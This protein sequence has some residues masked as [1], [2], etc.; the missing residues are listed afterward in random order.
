MEENMIRLETENFVNNLKPD[1][2]AEIQIKRHLAKS[3][4]EED[5]RE[6]VKVATEL[7][8]LRDLRENNM[9]ICLGTRNNHERDTFAAKLAE[10]KVHSLDI[11]PES[12]AD[13]IM[14]FT[15]FPK[16]WTCKWDLI[17]SNSIDHSYDPTSTFEE[18]IRVLKPSGILML[19]MNYG[20]VTSITDICAFTRE[21]VTNYLEQRQ[22]IMILK[23]IDGVL[24]V[25]GETW[26]IQKIS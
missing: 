3:G 17:Y 22:D 24:N 20:T 2:Y 10:V 26:F 11:S 18:W 8:S 15:K 1:N 12:S 4:K 6:Y 13:F 14:D 25:N 9:M 19:G 7:R 21:S 23:K 5:V 16:D